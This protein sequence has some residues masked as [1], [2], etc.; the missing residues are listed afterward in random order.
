[1][2]ISELEE[3][4]LQAENGVIGPGQVSGTIIS[5]VLGKG[6]GSGVQWCVGLGLMEMPKVFGSGST[7]ESALQNA[8]K[9]FRKAMKE[10]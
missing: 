8:L 3:K 1:M 6:E 10:C 4:I 9:K 2:S 5:R 7:I